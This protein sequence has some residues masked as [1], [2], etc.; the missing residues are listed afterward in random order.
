[1]WCKLIHSLPACD[2]PMFWFHA[3]YHERCGYLP[4]V[5]WPPLVSAFQD[6]LLTKPK[7]HEI[8]GEGMVRQM[9]RSMQTMLNKKVN[10]IKVSTPLTHLTPT[11]GGL[12]GS[13]IIS[14]GTT[15]PGNPS[16]DANPD[17]RNRFNRDQNG[18]NKS[19]YSFCVR[20]AG[21]SGFWNNGFVIFPLQAICNLTA[22]L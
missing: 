1:M 14:T 7:V 19:M 21:F 5:K 8:H 22:Y 12:Q 9:K 15:F 17:Q 11:P 6:Y 16:I 18:D 3:C 10:A 20:M 4:P 2:T 13:V